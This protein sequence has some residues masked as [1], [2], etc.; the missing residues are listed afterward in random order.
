LRDQLVAAHKK[1]EEQQ[2]KLE[3]V[4]P[5]ALLQELKLDALLDAKI[6][7]LIKRL[8]HLKAI[9]E[10]IRATEHL[11]VSKPVRRLTSSSTSPN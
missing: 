10:M 8:L 9:K 11:P 5:Q 6:D 2:R 7:R 3:L 4:R 1:S